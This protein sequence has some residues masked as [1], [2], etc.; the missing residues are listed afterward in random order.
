MDDYVNIIKLTLEHY[1]QGCAKS[2]QLK[3]DSFKQ[4]SN[5]KLQ[6]R[7]EKYLRLSLTDRLL[8][9]TFV[10]VRNLGLIAFRK[11]DLIRA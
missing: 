7:N 10:N 2:F 1:R 4:L 3:Q 11:K 8:M 9:S 6:T 5:L